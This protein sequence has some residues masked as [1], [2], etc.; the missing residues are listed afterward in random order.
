MIWGDSTELND[1]LRDPS[2]AARA[3][4][5]QATRAA[6]LPIADC[7]SSLPIADCRFPFEIA[8]CRCV[9]HCR[10]P[11]P[12]CRLIGYSRHE[13]FSTVWQDVRYGARL[14]RRSPG[15]TL[16]AIV[17]LALGIGVNTAL[18]SI[19][20]AL[21]YAPLHVRAPDELVYVYKLTITD[22][23]S[24][25]ARKQL[26]GLAALGA[27]IADFTTHGWSSMNLT[28]DGDTQ[29]AMVETVEG[30]Y[31][32]LLGVQMAAGRRARDRP[33]SI[34]PRPSSPRSSVTPIGSNALASIPPHWAKR[35][36]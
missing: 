20:N 16:V 18:F 11:I 5:R 30:N 15:F 22:R 28:V 29:P 25:M 24:P 27:G 3:T 10:L 14:M 26:D 4:A 31:F 19:V 21:F 6:L 33:T 34:R 7:R 8:D 17:V 32:S 13:M 2:P 9:S 1:C 23:T 35:S 36:D 12:H